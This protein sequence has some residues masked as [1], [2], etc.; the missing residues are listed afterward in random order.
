MLAYPNV[1][2]AALL[3]MATSHAKA[4]TTTNTKTNTKGF[5]S[6][7]RAE[8]LSAMKSAPIDGKQRRARKQ[9]RNLANEASPDTT[10]SIESVVEEMKGDSKSSNW[11]RRKIFEKATFVSPEE[12]RKR[13]RDLQNNNNYGYNNGKNYNSNTNANNNNDSTDDYFVA[14]GTWNNAFGFNPAQYSLSYLRC[15]EVKQF[16]D[17]L[18]AT[19]DSTS[20]FSTKHFAI[21]R[22]CPAKTCDLVP[23]EED[24]AAY[25]SSNNNKNAN[26]N[27]AM[28][29]QTAANANMVNQEPVWGAAGEGCQSN[30]GEY[31]IELEDYLQIMADYRAERFEVYCEYCEAC[32]YLVYTQWIKFTTNQGSD[33]QYNY[34]YNNKNKKNRDLYDITQYEEWKRE[35]EEYEE[36]KQELEEARKLGN[37]A[38]NPLSY[39]PEYNTCKYYA[40]LC[41]AGIDDTLEDYFECTQVE[42]ASNGQVAYIGPHCSQDGVTVTLGVY[43]DE[44]CNDYIGNGVDIKNFLGYELE[45]DALADYV[46][47]SLTSLTIP[48]NLRDYYNPSDQL[49]IPCRSMAQLYEN[50]DHMSENGGYNV[51][52]DDG[53]M[54][55]MFDYYTCYLNDYSALMND[56]QLTASYCSRTTIITTSCLQAH[57]TTKKSTNSAKTSTKCPPAATTTIAATAPRPNNP[58]TLTQT[59]CSYHVTSLTLSSWENMMKWDLSFLIIRPCPIPILI[60]RLFS[61]AAS[62]MKSMVIIS[63]KLVRFKSLDCARVFW[64]V[65]FSHFGWQS[66]TGL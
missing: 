21:F 2:T 31:M 28:Y 49:C 32:T 60:I 36:W 15:A 45:E 26:Y 38:F 17:E 54:L 52:T 25:Q 8:F 3:L 11:L 5:S 44:Y 56:F 23:V 33:Y 34:S 59:T 27:A 37:N 41:N 4:A 40:D 16:D 64:R 20:V 10:P 63:R 57:T 22:F 7:M 30:Y 46:K 55:T 24:P 62:T 42:R 66:C 35:L 9:L 65:L 6:Q 43:S 18:A 14:S 29:G 48:E 39:C 12:V 1:A 58:S 50:E 61:R 51:Y 53:E 19:E 47:G 13:D